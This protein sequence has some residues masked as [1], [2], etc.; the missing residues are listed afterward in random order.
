MKNTLISA[1]LIAVT[2]NSASAQNTPSFPYQPGQLIGAYKGYQ[3]HQPKVVP[4]NHQQSTLALPR[5]APAPAPSIPFQ[6]HEL[7]TPL[8]SLVAQPVAPVAPIGK[9]VLKTMKSQERVGEQLTLSSKAPA[10]SIP[11]QSDEFTTPLSSLV[12][13]PV[14][15]EVE[16]NLNTAESQEVTG[17][18]LALPNES[19]SQTII[20]SSKETAAPTET[21]VVASEQEIKPAS[22]LEM[23]DMAGELVVTPTP[24]DVEESI[25]LTTETEPSMLGLSLDADSN[26]PVVA[27]TSSATADEPSSDL[28]TETEPSMLGSSIDTDTAEPVVAATSTATTDESSSD[29]AKETEPS[30]LGSSIDTDTAEPVIAATPSATADESS[31]E[32]AEHVVTNYANEPISSVAVVPQRITSTP[33][34]T[35]GKEKLSV[36]TAS[37]ESQNSFSYV[38]WLLGLVTMLAV[39][40]VVWLVVRKRR[41]NA[42][43]NKFAER[44]LSRVN[45]GM[46]QPKKSRVA[47]DSQT[48]S[49]KTKSAQDVSVSA[50]KSANANEVKVKR[51]AVATSAKKTSTTAEDFTVKSNDSVETGDDFTL[52]PQVDAEIKDLLHQAGYLRFSDLEKASEREIKLALSKNGDSFSRLDFSSWSSLAGLASRGDWSAFQSQLT[53]TVATSQSTVANSEKPVDASISQADELTKI[54]GIGPE[55]AE[56]LRAA[57]VTTFQ[58]LKDAGTTRL[59]EIL[60]AGGAK[61]ERID[62]SMWCR[63]AQFLTSGTWVQPNVVESATGKAEVTVSKPEYRIPEKTMDFS[64][65]N[66][67]VETESNVGQVEGTVSKP[68]YRIPEKTMDFSAA[69]EIVETEQNVDRPVAGQPTITITTPEYRLPEATKALPAANEIVETEPNVD[70]SVVG[71]PKATVT[72]PEYRVPEATKATATT[73][74]YRVPEATK[75]TATTPEYRVPEATIESPA[76]NE[77]SGLFSKGEVERFEQLASMAGQS[78]DEAALLEQIKSIRAIVGSTT[79]NV[80]Q[81]GSTAESTETVKK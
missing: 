68:E 21:V 17:E 31:N 56:L 77:T 5:T 61:F 6:P 59:Q 65:A 43:V 52:I 80:S 81:E 57:G 73:P 70:Q 28:A 13:Q 78:D 51:G 66:E 20:E 30:M 19:P 69:N 22:E 4:N 64:A 26:E 29:L 2:A 47:T 37:T 42:K 50:A 7:T 39:P 1:I 48:L 34:R 25:E 11:A 49:E 41:Q 76:A 46:P 45:A 14:N 72:T 32:V 74:E 53:A 12:A 36:K 3:L 24:N 18:L 35:A 9:S 27:T 23:E 62:P 67:I 60:D 54:R 75:A 16:N 40:R 44:A 58:A 71:Q 79:D 10:P 8:S 33:K 55:T 38:S 15:Q 63:Q